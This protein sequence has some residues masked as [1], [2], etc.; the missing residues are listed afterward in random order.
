MLSHAP[1]LK[2]VVAYLLLAACVVI[3]LVGILLLAAP[4]LKRDRTKNNFTKELWLLVWVA[5]GI[6]A[7]HVLEILL[8]ALFYLSQGCMA[9]LAT[10]FYFSSITYTTVGF[11]DVV[12]APEWRN[13]AGA[14]ALTGILMA[15]LSTGFFYFLFSRSL[16]HGANS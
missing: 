15:G 7:L 8:W 9:D 14:E 11:G 12:L 6:V 13:F 16:R 3:H 5:W 10:A 2:L 1:I 4:A